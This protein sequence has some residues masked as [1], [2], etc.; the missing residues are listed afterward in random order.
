[1]LTRRITPKASESPT[2]IRA[3]RPPKRAPW[4]NVSMRFSMSMQAEVCPGD[5]LSAER[6]CAARQGHAS[7]LEAVDA[8]GR[9]QRLPDILLDKHDGDPAGAD[10]CQD[11]VDVL[12]H[13]RRQA[14]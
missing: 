12:H 1:M 3:Y 13:R 5:V 8:V 6:V 4:S 11:C 7:F 2:A 14:E 9:T 10:A